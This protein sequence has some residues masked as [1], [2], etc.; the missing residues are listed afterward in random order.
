MYTFIFI[1]A[2]LLLNSLV[3]AEK[4]QNDISEEQLLKYD[5]VLKRIQDRLSDKIPIVSIAPAKKEPVMFS[6]FYCNGW[7]CNGIA[8]GY[9]GIINYQGAIIDKIIF[10]G[11]YWFDIYGTVA[12]YSIKLIDQDI[13]K[14][15][16]CTTSEGLPLIFPAIR[17]RNQIPV[18]HVIDIVRRFT[19]NY[20]QTHIYQL[21]QAEMLDICSKFTAQEIMF[22][23]YDR[24]NELLLT[25]LRVEN[26]RFDTKLLIQSVTITDKPIAPAAITKNYQLLAEFETQTKVL[27]AEKLKTQM[28]KERDLIEAQGNTAILSEKANSENNRKIQ[29]KRADI[30]IAY[31]TIEAKQKEALI[32]N[33]IK[34]SN[35]KIE[36]ESNVLIAESLK[37]YWESQGWVAVKQA[38]FLS[39]NTK[40][41]G[42]KIPNMVLGSNL[43][44]IK[45]SPFEKN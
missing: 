8:E 37:P 25:A 2:F 12:V 20:D 44:D 1:L 14:D 38:E 36:A 41:I 10:P 30:Q 13:V 34:L 42:N 19:I 5:S 17:V 28:Q 9:V 23:Y 3:F 40:I 11:P 16:Q 39:T 35:A 21:L 4:L 6:P 27:E 45:E 29:E 32:E 22:T 26:L 43:F 7:V 31:E 15:V 24:L 33:Q 18:E